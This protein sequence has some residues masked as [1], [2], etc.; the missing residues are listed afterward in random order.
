MLFKNSS[1]DFD[2]S[3][4]TFIGLVNSNNKGGDYFLGV[5]I[6]LLSFVFIG[7]VPLILISFFYNGA[8]L[9]ELISLIDLNLLFAIILFP[10]LIGFCAILFTNNLILKLP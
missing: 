4:T 6:V 10:F 5:I 2:D 1:S 7:Q 9:D 3:K 8:R